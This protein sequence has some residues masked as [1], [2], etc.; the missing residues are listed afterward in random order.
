MRLDMLLQHSLYGT[1][2]AEISDS[3][4]PIYQLCRKKGLSPNGLQTTIPSPLNQATQINMKTLKILIIILW[5]RHLTSG[6]KLRLVFLL[7]R[8]IKLELRR[9]KGRGLH[10]V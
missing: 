9:L 4:A 6:S 10:K 7:G 8:L 1:L 3:L 5:Q 2:S